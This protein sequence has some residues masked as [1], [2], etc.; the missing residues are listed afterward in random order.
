M[1]ESQFQSKLIRQY[2]WE[3]WTVI[4]L[5]QANR[6]GYPDLLLL[7]PNDVRFVE[8]KAPKGKL[9]KVQEYR[10]AELRCKGFHVEVLHAEQK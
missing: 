5:I 9:S 7:K 1:T 6:A 2:E 10:I 8:V 3:G 4:K